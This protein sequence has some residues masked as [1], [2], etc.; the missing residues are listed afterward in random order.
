MMIS[1]MHDQEIVVKDLNLN[2]KAKIVETGTLMM[3]T[4]IKLLVSIFVIFLVLIS[5]NYSCNYYM[6]TILANITNL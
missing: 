5:C 6:S 4:K 3:K 1:G 2:K